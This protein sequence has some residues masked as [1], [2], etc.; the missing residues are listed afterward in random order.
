MFGLLR[1]LFGNSPPAPAAPAAAP[2]LEDIGAVHAEF[3]RTFCHRPGV[4]F[5]DFLQAEGVTRMIDWLR[6]E[7]PCAVPRGFVRWAVNITRQGEHVWDKSGVSLLYEGNAEQGGLP[8][9]ESLDALS[10]LAQ[11]LGKPVKLF[12]RP[13]PA[14]DLMVMEYAP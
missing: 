13:R 7:T 14:A 4:N 6:P 9:Q 5:M 8:P 1:K 3:C 11:I 2:P 12:H 10:V